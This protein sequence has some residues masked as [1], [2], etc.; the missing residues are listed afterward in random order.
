[1]WTDGRIV[2][3]SIIEYATTEYMFP[4]RRAYRAIFRKRKPAKKRVARKRKQRANANNGLVRVKKTQILN[5]ISVNGNVTAYGSDT[6]EMSDLV[7]SGSY[8][9]LYEE[10][11]IDKIVYSFKALNNMAVAGASVGYATLGMI[12]SIIDTNDSTPPASIQ[13]LMND[14]TYKGSVSNRNHTRIIRPK[15]LN[16][17]GGGVQ[18]QS[19]TGWLN[20]D[21]PT[22]SHYG[23]KYALE[24]GLVPTAG[25]ISYFV[26][27]IVTYY[28]SFRNPK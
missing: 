27:P 26:E 18:G 21:Q 25:Q 13:S 6:F 22:I 24:G 8:Q 28:M 12:H 2:G 16:E 17:V 19:K 14:S 7:Q 10:Y 1:M 23:I 3:F 20:T 9:T 15:W 11:R 5:R 4:F